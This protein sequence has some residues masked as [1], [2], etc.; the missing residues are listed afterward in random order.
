[1][2]RY[3]LKPDVPPSQ[4]LRAKNAFRVTRD[5]LVYLPHQGAKEKARREKQM[6]R[7]RAKQEAAARAEKA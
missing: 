2:E 7:Q 5:R 1:M 6:A 3:D 4:Q